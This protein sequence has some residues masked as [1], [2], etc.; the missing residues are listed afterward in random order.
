MA[1]AGDAVGDRSQ[2]RH[3]WQQALGLYA[4]LGAP[5][6]DQ[7]RAQLAAVGGGVQD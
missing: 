5:E 6:A 3:H 4:Q 1:S 7:V 2:A